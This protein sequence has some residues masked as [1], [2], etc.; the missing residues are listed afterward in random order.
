M[1]KREFLERLKEALAENLSSAAVQEQ[2]VFYRQYIENEVRQGRS[3]EAVTAELG[4]PWVIARTLIDSAEMQG[5][6]G[7]SDDYEPERQSRT[8]YREEAHI[9][10]FGV[11]TWW[12]KLLLA[13][14]AVGIFL[15]VI[16]VIGGIFSL[17]LPILIPLALI[18]LI[19]RL[20]N[21]RK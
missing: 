19:F 2:I 14:G 4:D 16:A 8:D 17:L 18:S 20:L 7:R 6:A 9:H 11:D 1:T 12:K 10:V 3:E 15:L 21:G 13:L 5:T